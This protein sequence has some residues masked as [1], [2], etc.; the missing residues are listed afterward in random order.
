M[1]YEN[2][3]FISFSVI[4]I[5]FS[6][7]IFAAFIL[8]KTKL[9]KH[10]TLISQKYFVQFC[11]FAACLCGLVVNSSESNMKNEISNSQWKMVGYSTYIIFL[12]VISFA[13]NYENYLSTRDPT[14]VFRILI[15]KGNNYLLVD[16]II[17]SIVAGYVCIGLLFKLFEED[18]FD[19]EIG[20]NL[21][22]IIY[23]D[24]LLNGFLLFVS[25]I[26]LLFY[27]LNRMNFKNYKFTSIKNFIN[28]N[29]FSLLIT[30]FFILYSSYM[31]F[32]HLIIPKQLFF[33]IAYSLIFIL[34]FVD[35][36]FQ[37]GAIYN[38]SFYYYNLGSSNLGIFFCCFGCNKFYS[39]PLFYR[40]DASYRTND[41]NLFMMN[42]Y[43]NIG[44]T[45]DDYIIE[46]FDYEMN[47]STL[48]L[49]MLY[50]NLRDGHQIY[51]KSKGRNDFKD[52]DRYA[53]N[54]LVKAGDVEM[55]IESLFSER[56]K[57]TMNVFHITKEKIISSLLSHKFS[58]FLSKNAKEGYFKTLN[59][60]VVKSY[61][62][63]LL[64]EI[65]SGFKMDDKMKK[66]IDLYFDHI[67]AEQINTF[68]PIL[69]GVFK[70]KINS[71]KE[72]VIFISMNPL[73]EDVP[74]EHFNFW[75]LNRFEYP[76]KFEKIST[77]KDRD[78]FIITTELV[79]EKN[80]KFVINDYE[81]FHQT[82]EKDLAFFKR[83][84]SSHFSMLVL[85]YEYELD[86]D[87]EKY[88]LDSST[89]IQVKSNNNESN[90][91]DKTNFD[92]LNNNIICVNDVINDSVDSL[93]GFE[94]M[95]MIGYSKDAFD[96]TKPIII[97]NGF[98]S[99]YNGFRGVVFFT[100]ENIFEFGNCWYRCCSSSHFYKNYFKDMLRFFEN[101][102]ENEI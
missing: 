79:F 52:C 50:D 70:I 57:E 87:K 13:I 1:A 43:N 101:N 81:M 97:K 90:S 66:K 33:E 93:K 67:T 6:S 102:N 11:F 20:K 16:L 18:K 37:I 25:V 36:F 45:V 30:F 32:A 62:K 100:F 15:S 7:I 73:V 40:E 76:K 88:L 10:D 59:N 84:N 92:S 14:H 3:L 19:K 21:F 83:I 31:L 58:S 4:N 12:F 27:P 65:H 46:A 55:Q 72:I 49:S 71:F 22:V 68:I 53:E 80:P 42:L 82:L 24:K 54:F 26:T 35:S 28:S 29:R 63:K 99:M 48:G 51:K 86:K 69:V 98:D 75:Q 78:S 74:R 85:Y 56:I 41:K 61:D 38:S 34:G 47:L 64:L 8:F 96:V 77:S 95:S 39:P 94:D 89:V 5:I 60:L 23:K 9:S 44:F 2:I 91:K 17:I